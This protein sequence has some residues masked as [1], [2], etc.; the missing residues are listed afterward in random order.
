M[1][2]EN[3]TAREILDS[4]GN[5]TVSA[6]VFLADGIIAEAS[7][8]SGASTG[9]TEAIELRDLDKKRYA[10]Q[11]ELRAVANITEIIAPVLIGKDAKDQQK[12]DQLICELDGTEN[13]RHLGAN[14]T[15]AVSLAVARAQALSDD[16]ELFEYL[17]VKYRGSFGKKYQIPT[18]MFNIVNGGKH[19]VNNIDIQEAMI[20]PIGLVSFSDKLMAGSEIYHI[21]KSN[22]SSSGYSVGLGDEGGFAPELNKNEDIF[23]L[24]EQAIKDS[25]YDNK[26][27]RISLDVAASSFYDVDKGS[28]LLEGGKK[29]LVSYKMIDLMAGWSKKYQLLSIEDGLSENDPHWT[30]LTSK[31]KP[32]ISI[33]DDLFTTHTAKIKEGAKKKMASGVI[34]KPNQVGT[35][36]ETFSAIKAAQKNNFTVII[37][38]RSG[39][40]DDSFIAD[41]AVAVG[42]DFIKSGAPARSERLAK[43]NR[44]LRIE[45]IITKERG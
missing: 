32:S 2:I 17:G 21:L 10:G 7:V 30:E 16:L 41:L 18:P 27:I 3:I 1:K 43:Y 44:L 23:E 13:K 19:A 22:L 26:K 24:L 25:G 9:E 40:T 5:P 6:T 36:T 45:E 28:Y 20:V 31:I 29:T 39:E 11:G 38:H 37:S 12:I 42:A 14:S 15:L 8:P 34:I 4:R 33:G 35:L